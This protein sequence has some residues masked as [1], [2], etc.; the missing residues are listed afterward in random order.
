MP[1]PN[2]NDKV[3]VRNRNYLNVKNNPQN[4]WQ[5]SAG[6]D[7]R[8]HTIF[9]APEW[10]LRAAIM[11]LRTYWFSYGLRTVSAILARWAPSNDTLGS[12]AGMPPNNPAEYTSFVCKRMRVGPLDDLKLFYSDRRL[13]DVR[14]LQA[15]VEAMAEF[16]IGAGFNVPDD[17]FMKALALVEPDRAPATPG[18]PPPPSVPPTP[19]EPEIRRA[20]PVGG[21]EVSD[22]LLRR[23]LALYAS[24]VTKED[25]MVFFGF[26]GCVPARPEDH[27]FS[28]FQTLKLSSLNY[29]N[30]RCVIG[31]WKPDEGTVSVFPG[32]TVPTARYVAA[33]A[34]NNQGNTTNQLFPGYYKFITGNHSLG[35]PTEHRAFRQHGRRIY[36]RT[37]DDAI[38]EHTDRVETGVPWDNLHAAF[39]DSLTGTYSSAGCQVVLGYPKCKK[40]SDKAP[41]PEFR[42][43]AYDTNQKVFRYL[44][45]DAAIAAEISEDLDAQQFLRLHCG[46]HESGLPPGMGEIIRDVQSKLGVKP[47]GD[48]GATSALETLKLQQKEFGP[49]QADG[50]VGPQ[51]A[52]VLGIQNW[53]VL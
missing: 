38:Y 36:R 52:E 34:E 1:L 3:G 23:L 20:L 19:A 50:V 6:A 33:S 30:P 8:G 44:L 5:G 12:R 26:R 9:R 13:N 31:Q 10:G 2:Y 4:P 27:S 47:D 15:L 14:N 22:A 24:P 25:E 11:T 7:A 41:W 46:S 32:S 28:S 29:R 42:D 16:E 37:A 51:T 48:F 40:F 35:N 18:A 17:E 43:R 49:S 45:L 21:F 53:P 39:G